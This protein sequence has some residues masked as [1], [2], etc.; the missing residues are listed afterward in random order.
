[1]DHDSLLHAFEC[2]N[3][4]FYDSGQLKSQLKLFSLTENKLIKTPI[5]NSLL[6]NPKYKKYIEDIV[7]Y[8]IFRYEKEFRNEFYGVPHFKL[9]EQFKM[10]DAALLSNFRKSHSSYRGSGLLTNGKD[11]FLYIDLHKEVDVEKRLNYQDEIVDTRH[12]QWQTPHTTA[13]HTNTGQNII[14]NKNRG[15]N[16]HLFVRKY[17]QIDGKNE[18]FIY[19]GKGNAIRFEGN[20]PITVQ[21]ELENELPVKLFTEF[22]KKVW[23]S[24]RRRLFFMN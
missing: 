12:F 23:S 24:P 19:I 5:F 2:W 4:N 8:G 3:Q 9:Y 22:T 10:A 6:G 7:H 20:N 14:Y 21:L 17:K 15:I 18:P 1:M 11:Y 16:L 13:Q